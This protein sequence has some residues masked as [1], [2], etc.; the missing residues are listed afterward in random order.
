MW[1]Y[2]DLKHLYN[3]HTYIII[4]YKLDVQM[5]VRNTDGVSGRV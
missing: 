5:S 2:L 3:V 1:K 4:Y